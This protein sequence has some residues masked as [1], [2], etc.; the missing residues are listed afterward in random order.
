MSEL[1]LLKKYNCIRTNLNHVITGCYRSYDD[2]YEKVTDLIDDFIND[3]VYCDEKI[4]NAYCCQLYDD[5][6]VT[7]G[8]IYRYVIAAFDDISWMIS[9]E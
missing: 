1:E 3:L 9:F 5:A 4:F 2:I 8:N 6:K 7:S